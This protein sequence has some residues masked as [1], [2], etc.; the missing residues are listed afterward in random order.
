MA[1]E[2]EQKRHIYD[3]TASLITRQL[4]TNRLDTMEMHFL[5]HLLDE[6]V[7]KCQ[8]RHLLDDLHRWLSINQGAVNEEIKQ[9]LL[10]INLG[11]EKS[12]RQT[13]M[14]IQKLLKDMPESS[15]SGEGELDDQ[16]KLDL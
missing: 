9:A 15:D 14:F 1:N 5:L 11:D 16:R 3:E 13:T 12:V 10:N 7:I 8:H 6:V 4:L 2:E